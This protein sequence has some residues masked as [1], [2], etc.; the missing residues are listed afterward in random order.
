MY[1]P[2][3]FNETFDT[4]LFKPELRGEQLYRFACE[5]IYCIIHDGEIR[6]SE[7]Q[8]TDQFYFIRLLEENRSKKLGLDNVINHL[9]VV[10]RPRYNKDLG[11]CDAVTPIA[12]SLAGNLL[13]AEFDFSCLDDDL[14]KDYRRN[15][16]QTVQAKYKNLDNVAKARKLLHQ[17]LKKAKPSPTDQIAIG[18]WDRLLH[19]GQKHRDTGTAGNVESWNKQSSAQEGLPLLTGTNLLPHPSFENMTMG[20]AVAKMC[21]KSRPELWK[22]CLA[23]V[24]HLLGEALVGVATQTEVE[25]KRKAH[26]PEEYFNSRSKFYTAR[27][28]WKKELSQAD[29][30]FMK[31]M[32]DSMYNEVVA[33]SSNAG[34]RVFMP[35]DP[36][37]EDQNDAQHLVANTCR[38]V[39]QNQCLRMAYQTAPVKWRWNE[40]L[41]IVQGMN[42][43]LNNKAFITRRAAYIRAVGPRAQW[44]ALLRL[45]GPLNMAVAAAGGGVRLLLNDDAS[46]TVSTVSIST[47][48]GETALAT[49]SSR[50]RRFKGQGECQ[51]HRV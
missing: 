6:L 10:Q 42:E 23:F 50:S 29:F 45:Q 18:Y 9:R 38:P 14:E 8:G 43:V 26:L 19:E 47:S 15:I 31:E 25:E 34:R 2:G 11:R 41:P 32:L 16:V 44:Q 30:L 5:L 39:A 7:P 22:Q 28:L 27:D 4:V 21:S 48:G 12:E 51:Q 37:S 1:R 24:D 20:A 49:S 13:N 46:F 3:I 36:F 17:L 35:G 33:N 40:F